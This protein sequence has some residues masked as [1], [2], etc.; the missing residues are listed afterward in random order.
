MAILN[1]LRLPISI[2]TEL[3]VYLGGRREGAWTLGEK[4]TLVI[5]LAVCSPRPIKEK[6]SK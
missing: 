4:Q 2:S 1:W 3:R 5:I 6:L